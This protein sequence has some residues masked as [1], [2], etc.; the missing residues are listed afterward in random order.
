MHPRPTIVAIASLSMCALLT[1]CSTQP[2]RHAYEAKL[3]RLKVNLVLSSWHLAA[4]QGLY[5]LYFDAMTDDA[6]FLGTDASERWTKQEFMNY[7]RE[8]FSDGNGW[9]YAQLEYHIAFNDTYDTA[10]VD[11]ILVNEKYGTMRGTAVLELIG[12]E[13]KIAHYSLTFLVPNEK[14]GRVVE[15]I[16]GD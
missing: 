13:W 12:D 16:A 3:D 10:W 6:V 5:D 7:A 14:A 1:G 8:P 11:E 4:S 15:A 9:A 2:T